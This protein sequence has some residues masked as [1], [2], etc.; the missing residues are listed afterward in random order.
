MPAVG[1]DPNHPGGEPHRLRGAG[2]FE[3]GKPDRPPGTPTLPRRRPGLQPAGQPIQAGVV[4][5]LGILAPLIVITTLILL[6]LL[7]GSVVLPVRALISNVLSLTAAFGALVWI[8][9]DGNLGALGTTATDGLVPMVPLLLFCVAFGLS[10]DYEVFLLSRIREFWLESDGSPRANRES[11][12]EG[13]ARTGKV[14]T[15]AAALMV[16]VFSAVV[17][18]E[19]SLVRMFGVGL[20]L[21]VLVDATLVRMLLLPA[22]MRAMGRANWWAPAPLARLHIRLSASATETSDEPLGQ[23]CTRQNG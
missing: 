13:V 9:Q 20:V 23:K 15:V 7:T 21:A 12:A 6:F 1:L 4:G 5:L 22:V 11:V 10:M 14:V 17:A 19:V 3:P 16:I 2:R 18:A 8:F